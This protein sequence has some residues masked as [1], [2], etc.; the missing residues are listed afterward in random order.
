MDSTI[1]TRRAALCI[2]TLLVPPMAA[3]CGRDQEPNSSTAVSSTPT[4][5]T[6]SPSLGSGSGGGGTGGSAVRGTPTAGSV[7]AGNKQ[8]APSGSAGSPVSATVPPMA[9]AGGASGSAP[10]GAT[11]VSAG[12]GGAVAAAGS[13]GATGMPTSGVACDPKDMT[14]E[15][16]AVSYNVIVGYDKLTKEPTTGPLK[17]VIEVHSGFP[18]WTVYRPEPL[19]AE[20]K[21]PIVVFGNGGCLLNGTLFGQWTFELASYGIVSVVDGKPQTKASDDPIVNG[22]RPG[23]DGKPLVMALD[24]ITAENERPCS[25]FYHK[26]DLQKIA[27]AGQSC[28]GMMT[29]LSAGDKRVATALVLSSGLSGDNKTLFSTYHAPM[30]FI[31][32]GTSDMLH[33]TGLAN[34]KAIN[35]VPIWFGSQN[36]G[37]MGTWDQINAGEM[38]RA[39][40]GWIRWKL[41]GEASA[42]KMFVGA[43]CELCKPP[44][45]WVM[46]QKKMID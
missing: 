29:L 3:A 15:P 27:V 6:T 14:P 4:G 9:S 23:P 37:H 45:E 40:T 36:S 2:V 28:G 20:T 34:F 44:S 21:H 32:G 22:I 24:W 35:N 26:L 30:L 10:T 11:S 33:S 25:P 5:A 42:E 38:G 41:L 43:D 8:T 17:P 18:E 16:K 31:S 19:D 46:I 13:G 39:A 7:A 1:L 12:A